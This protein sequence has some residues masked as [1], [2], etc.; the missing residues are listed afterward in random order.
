MD[1][2]IKPWDSGRAFVSA[3]TKFE[4]DEGLLHVETV[5]AAQAESIDGWCRVLDRL[6][7][8]G[9]P[10][11]LWDLR[12]CGRIDRSDRRRLL[13]EVGP[14]LGALALIAETPIAQRVADIYVLVQQLEVPTALFEDASQARL[15]AHSYRTPLSRRPAPGTEPGSP[16]GS[17]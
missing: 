16:P 3:T 8:I 1:T 17:A 10:S 15:W 11:V 6:A 7:A 14:R 12:S 4:L 2:R 5:A 13:E 9:P